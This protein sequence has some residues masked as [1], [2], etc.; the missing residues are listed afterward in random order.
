MKE[1][2]LMTVIPADTKDIAPEKLLERIRQSREIIVSSSE[3][4]VNGEISPLKI[5]IRIESRE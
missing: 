5:P 2:S 1:S 4:D 3:Y